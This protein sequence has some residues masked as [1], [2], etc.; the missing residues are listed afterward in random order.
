MGCSLLSLLGLGLGVTAADPF[1][2]LLL[3]YFGVAGALG[4]FTNIASAMQE[5]APGNMRGT[6]I[7]VLYLLMN[8]VGYG[9]TPVVVPAVADLLGSSSDNLGEGL[10]TVCIVLS[11]IGFLLFAWVR[12]AYQGE[13]RAGFPTVAISDV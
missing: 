11:I 6:F 1:L 5:F 3:V 9:A 12:K 13:A 7:G 10:A 4:A 8:L 2:R